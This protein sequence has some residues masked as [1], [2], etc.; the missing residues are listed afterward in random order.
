LNAGKLGGLPIDTVT[1]TTA[2]NYGNLYVATKGD[3]GGK[4]GG[5]VAI[6]GVNNI[7]NG[8]PNV[9]GTILGSVS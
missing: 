8:Y 6:T 9:G 1:N 4:W 5:G 7:L 3:D 2:T